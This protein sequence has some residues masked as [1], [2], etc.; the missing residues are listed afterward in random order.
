MY[1]HPKT[2]IHWV[3]FVNVFLRVEIFYGSKMRFAI[4]AIISVGALASADVFPWPQDTPERHG[5]SGTELDAWRVRL[6]AV[7]TNALLVVRDDKIVYEWYA[8]GHGPDRKQ[9]TASLAKAIVGGSS[10][11]V[12]M[13]DHRIGI[14]DLASKYI[15][16][17]RGDSRKSRIT[18][19][20][21]ATH[22]SGIEDAEQDDI[23]HMQLPGW[24]GA[25]W[26]RTP[27]PFSIA[28]L[29]APVIFPSGSSF[30]YSNPGMA[31]LAYAV[32]AS[33][34]G[35][36]QTDIRTLLKAKLFDPL[37]IPESHWSIG[38][39]TPYQMDG[40]TLYANW[41]GGL[42]TPRATARIGQL[43]LHQGEW[44][45]KQLVNRMLAQTMTMYAGMPIRPRTPSSP[46]PGSGLCWWLNFDG[47]WSN[48]PRD[49][50]A[51]AGAG[52][53]LLLV[54]P[55]LELIVVRNGVA[56]G[57]KERFWRD[58]VDNVFDPIVAA[59]ASKPPYPRSQVIRG[60]SFAPESTVVREAIE[61][62]NWPIT[63]G[64]DDAQ[65]TSYG[66][67]WGFEPNTDRK[68]SLGLAKV[69]GPA[70]GFQG[71]NIRS[72]TGESVGDGAKGPKSSGMVMVDGVLYMLVRNTANSQLAWSE[73]HGGAWQWGFH[74]T[75]SFA[76][77]AFLNFGRNYASARDGFVYLYSQDGASAYESDD[78]LVMA[79]VPKNRL[80]DRQAYEFLE[81]VDPAG[82]PHWTKD[83]NARGPTF[84]FAGH[85]QRADVVYNPLL[86]RYL[87]ALGY[88]H[89]GGW[90]IF[91]A[92][93]P[94]G[95]WTTVFHT[96]YWGL[97]GTHG[98][99]LPAKWIGP[100]PKNMTLVFSGVKMPA[101]TYD[102]FCVRQMTFELER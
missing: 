44:G 10:L 70:T 76:S 79:R 99:R 56:M 46:S 77:P 43:M 50:F 13:Q 91:D 21:L 69:I 15:P 3:I 74:F 34:K 9:G 62:D 39:N 23:D 92:P 4:L 51:G 65:Y 37:G 20:Q 89:K 100:D 67:G 22:T 36:P 78:A 24:K 14:D 40:L 7:G 17:W 83:I 53:E 97:G 38:Y 81:R 6:A 54:V 82:Q 41:G 68:L 58:A 12:A 8:E 94:W 16:A 18:V 61:S 48:I 49:A 98:Y 1:L 86:K 59:A 31:A 71:V 19:R 93:E 32:T 5:M 60:V 2:S 11:M 45:G 85:C 88:N 57:S 27:D 72:Q 75:T 101:T 96:D 66:D 25:F 33:L 90:G 80:R 87:L 55:S 73:D 26:K 63:W 84:R 95:P 29:Q 52:Q 42:F 64:D 28:I 102:A 47:I 35:A 30:E